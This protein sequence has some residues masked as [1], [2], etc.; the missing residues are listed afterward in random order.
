VTAADLHAA[1]LTLLRTIGTVT[2]H[3]G[4]VP[5]SPAADPSGRTYPYAVL[6]PSAGFY[7]STDADT[8]CEEP[9]D[10][11]TWPVQVTVAAGDPT[12]CLQA[13]DLVRK[14]L[15]KAR[16][17][18]RSGLLRQDEVS[19]PATLDPAVSPARWFIPLLFRTQSA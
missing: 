5:P 9:G 10:E 13:A 12:W 15:N 19:I 4:K 2:I 16:L 3:D 11:L 8:L 7:P 14:K 6:W 18:P 1:T 17:T